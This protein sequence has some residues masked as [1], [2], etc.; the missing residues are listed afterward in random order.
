MPSRESAVWP[1]AIEI[2]IKHR[3]KRNRLH[4]IGCAQDVVECGADRLKYL[5]TPK[6]VWRDSFI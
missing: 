4:P 3:R 1:V 6:E 5:S 2:A